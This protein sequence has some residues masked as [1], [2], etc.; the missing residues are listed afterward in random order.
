M[1]PARYLIWRQH[2]SE[3]G[4]LWDWL[5]LIILFHL[6]LLLVIIEGGMVVQLAI[7]YSTLREDVGS[8]STS[9][10]TT[11]YVIKAAAY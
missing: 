4:N 9:D 5:H 3:L 11:N 7:N 8:K 10:Y 6:Q 1:S 2:C